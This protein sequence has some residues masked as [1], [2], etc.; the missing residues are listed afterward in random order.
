MS[1]HTFMIFVDAAYEQIHIVGARNRS[2]VDED[3]EHSS[4]DIVSH[5]IWSRHVLP[6]L[7]FY[8]QSVDVRA[9]DLVFGMA[10][11]E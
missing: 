3:L 5:P 2:T 7:E 1:D 10:H 4:I 9:S 6:I 11:K 8:L